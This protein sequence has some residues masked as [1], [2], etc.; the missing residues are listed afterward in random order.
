MHT[1]PPSASRPRRPW[2]RI[3]LAVAGG[4]LFLLAVALGWLLGT[5]S[6]LRFALLEA[7][8]LTQGAL[9]LTQAQGRLIGPIDAAT[10]HY[11][12]GKGTDISIRQMHLDW[13]LTDLLYKR[14]HVTDL[15]VGH[16][17]VT[18]P[19]APTSSPSPTFSLQPPIEWMLD[20]AQLGPSVILR[21]HQP[22][23]A[24]DRLDLA[25]RWTSNEI[26][27]DRLALR[28]PQGHLDLAGRLGF[29][30][31]YRG[32][33]HAQ[34]VWNLGGTTYAAT[35]DAQGNGQHAQ[36]QIRLTQ[37]MATQLTIDVDQ[38]KNNAWT[39]R[40]IAP[41]FDPAP[42][43][44]TTSLT[45]LGAHIQ[46]R[47][48]AHSGTLNGQL[49]LDGYHVMLQPLQARIDSDFKT[50]TLQQLKLSSP[51]MKGMIHAA[52]TIQL[53]ATPISAKLDLDWRALELPANLVG[54]VLDTQGHLTIKG[55]AKAYH[56]EGHLTIG[57]PGKPATLALNLDGTPKQL[58]LHS[59][60]LEQ[61]HGHL[62]TTGVLTLQ[63][64]LAWQL[65]ASAET[66]DPGLL[67][68]NWQGSL[69]ADFSTEGQWDKDHPQATLDLRKL[70]GQLRQRPVRGVGK[71]HLSPD[72]VIDGTL[73]LASGRSSIALLAR[74][75]ASNDAKLTLAVASLNDWL[76][77]VNGRLNGQLQIRGKLS[78][79][80]IQGALHGEMLAW[81]TQ[82]VRQLQLQ[83]NVPDLSRPGGKLDLDASGVNT[84]KLAFRQIRLNAQGTSANHRLTLHAAGSPLSASLALQGSLKE[85]RW[86]GLLSSLTLDMQGLPPWHLQQA[87]RLSWS[88]GE[89]T[90]AELCLT[91]GEPLLCL[92][93]KL[94]KNGTAEAAYRLRAVPLALITDALS[95]SPLPATVEGILSGNGD[96]R[97]S[98]AGA[99][100][101]NASIS[102]PLGRV[103]Y[104]E[105]ADQ[106]LLTYRNLTIT[107]TLAPD[108][109]QASVHAALNDNGRLDGQI[110]VRGTQQ[111]L[112]GQLGLHLDNLGFIELFTDELANVQGRADGNF[113]LGGTLH[114]P[115]LTGQVA[116]ENVAA[117]VPDAGLK[118]THGRLTVS[119]VNTQ[120]LRI[121]GSVT[122]GKGTLAIN[123]TAGLDAQT[124]SSISLVGRAFTAMD[125]PAAKVTI[126]P[127]LL[128]RRD[129]QGIHATGSVRLDNADVNL[130]KLPGGG[131]NKASQDI[132]VVDQPQP[133]AQSGTLPIFAS[134]KVDLG[135]RTHLSGRGLDG[136]L[137]GVLTVDERPGRQTTGQGQLAVNGTYKAYGQ[138][139]H[140]Q[141]G[142]LLF[143]ST[144]IDNPGLNIKAARSLE[145]N[146]T[147]SEGEQVGLQIT[148]TARRPVL[149]VFSNP[150][151][152][153]SD[154]LS[155]L[156]T[157]KPL[158]QV[159]G[160]EGNMVNAA[161]Q[162]L[163]SATGNLLAKSIGSKL[164]IT[165]I[166]VSS[167]DAL[168]GGS[169]FTVGKYLSPRLYLSYGVG[170]FEPGQV[171]TLRYRISR[172]WNFEAQN[173]T[174]FN[175]ASFNYRVEK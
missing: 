31:T 140:I 51:Q 65:K 128:V 84:G 16:L 80:A 6:G 26:R 144:P 121:T 149:N 4:L 78:R 134:I 138:N 41:P 1:M 91:A 115:F 71:L 17:S 154:A 153:Q 110:T 163:G 156:V 160:G 32:N 68:A 114:Q 70:D 89:A 167:S 117:E 105:H 126:S 133:T 157:G 38:R 166:G 93:G 112:S 12:D 11:R 52:G 87:T 76:P 96:I 66:F 174:D 175:R 135:Q 50:L 92:H 124:P 145:P 75:G 74:P 120:Q 131:I 3:L 98:A 173:A 151:M 152:D 42:L 37:P 47:G 127:D 60:S 67:F 161:A 14:L 58:Q 62:T 99:L 40:L 54:Q 29:R 136:H 82:S 2:L 141:H 148:G 13:R 23:F 35:L 61:P 72:N 45:Q 33:G 107:A 10:L 48:D 102:S 119:A 86:N 20:T 122:S 170:L 43:L 94:G 88:G 24:F 143:A 36:W 85:Q 44:G 18:L 150:V 27:V 79:L 28:A 100:T 130:D 162:A 90:L 9:Q 83:M 19:T 104:H 165:D 168:S 97:R 113:K 73:T 137:S 63:P 53:D 55:S 146:A 164:G 59:L 56:S 103:I 30:R 15:R 171:I 69:D 8:N 132:V 7:Q 172:R 159:K 21:Q 142:Q 64:Q 22:L 25:G 34:G 147:V 116:L 101:G 39:A 5:T 125:I 106:P 81:Q 169:A 123:G 49:D 95:S 77:Q 129:T 155:Y 118:L 139:L 46:G 57:P 158:S 111:S 109:Q 108:N